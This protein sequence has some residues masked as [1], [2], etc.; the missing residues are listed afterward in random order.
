MPYGESTDRWT[1]IADELARVDGAAPGRPEQQ[2]GASRKHRRMTH[3]PFRFLRGSAQLFYADLAAGRVDLPA[4]LTAVPT[5]R[6]QGD[7]HFS[8]FGFLTE[9]GTHGD[10]V[11]WALNDF[12]DACGGHAIWDILRYGVSLFLVGDLCRG[13]L[14][15]RYAAEDVEPESGMTAPDDDACG[16]A[17]AAF[18]KAYAKTCKAMAKD[19][20]RRD[21]ALDAF[22]DD[23]FLAKSLRKAIRRTV[24]GRDFAKKSSLGKESLV[25]DGSLRFR[26]RPDRFRRPAPDRAE[27][28]R[29]A[30]RP[31]VDDAI[32]D[33]VERL[34]AGTGSLDIDR[35]YLL[36]GPADA[37]DPEW[38]RLAHVVEVKQQRPAMPIHHFSTV[39][40]VNRMNPAHLTVDSQRLM[41]R[42]ADMVLDEAVWEGAHWLVRSRHHARVG[43][44]PDE[45]LEAK[46]PAKAL[47]QYAKA[48][49]TVLAQAHARGDRRSVRFESAIG[50]AVRDNAE[51]LA[52]LARTYAEQATADWRLLRSMAG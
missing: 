17:M 43:V 36:V 5:T 28:V 32:L 16:E 7:C 38:T 46:K 26:D 50:P 48:C 35:Y 25:F 51:N 34:G 23:H 9:E 14:D 3:S 6:I 22:D 4:A 15:G 49:G 27:A 30:F 21:D 42:R 11:V 1:V 20:D 24:G 8:N 12:D 47:K 10:R 13:I 52:G 41:Q 2:P 19:P 29:T 39:S 44:D 33:V 18:L 45:L 40:P 31:F 37:D